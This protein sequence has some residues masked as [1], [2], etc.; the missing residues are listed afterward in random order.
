METVNNDLVEDEEL[1]CKRIRT[2]ENREDVPILV[3]HPPI[4]DDLIE[5]NSAT[6]SSSVKESCH[7]GAWYSHGINKLMETV[8]ARDKG[9]SDTARPLH[10]AVLDNDLK[11]VQRQCTVL[12]GRK[13]TL[14][15]L[16]NSG[17]V[18][19][20]DGNT[21]LHLAIIYG[22]CLSLNAIINLK[23]P[24][25]LP[26]DD[27]NGEG[28]APLHLSALRQKLMETSILIDK[29]AN[30]DL[31]DA[32]SGRTPLFHA[33]EM[34]NDDLMCLLLAAGANIHALISNESSAI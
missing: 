30:V 29:G 33:V 18:K 24:T 21:A 8:K 2:N 10:Y 20:N 22:D 12:C 4:N 23:D 11:T 7:S 13:N 5:S 17:K 16:N 32:R 28:Y 31:K 27:F 26:L 14:D 6:Q 34:L 19:D 25:D 15:M 1:P 3:D 9:M